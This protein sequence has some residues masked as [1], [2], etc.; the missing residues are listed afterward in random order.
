MR[1]LPQHQL[2]RRHQHINAHAFIQHEARLHHLLW[3]IVQLY[4]LLKDGL[5]DKDSLLWEG[6]QN[7]VYYY[8]Y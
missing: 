5:L 3:D 6:F 7:I 8:C 4:H 2:R 1:R